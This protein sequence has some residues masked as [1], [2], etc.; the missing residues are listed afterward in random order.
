[1]EGI[2]NI[3]S[4]DKLCTGSKP[5]FISGFFLSFSTPILCVRALGMIIFARF[6]ICGQVFLFASLPES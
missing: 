1:M 6:R 4:F 5:G 2:E 3:I